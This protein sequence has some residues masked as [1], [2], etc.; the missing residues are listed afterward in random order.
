[1][2]GRAHGITYD[3]ELYCV[4]ALLHDIGLTE[5]FDSHRLTVVA[6]GD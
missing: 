3:D 2:Y 5:A 4:S 6:S 1:M